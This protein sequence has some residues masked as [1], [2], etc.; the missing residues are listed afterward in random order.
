MKC[1]ACQTEFTPTAFEVFCSVDCTVA[2]NRKRQ[3]E[4]V[5]TCIDNGSEPHIHGRVCNP[6]ESE[7]DFDARLVKLAKELLW[8]S[9]HTHDSRKSAGGFPDRTFW[10]DRVFFAELKAED[11]KLSAAQSTVIEGLRSAGAEVYVWRPSD[12]PAIVEVLTAKTWPCAECG[13]PMHPGMN[14]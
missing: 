14:N 10:R 9:Y 1:R 13:L 8:D 5:G 12:W 2:G 6:A 4:G 7:E 11:G 3:F